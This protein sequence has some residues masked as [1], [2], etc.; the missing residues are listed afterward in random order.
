[1][2]YFFVSKALLRFMRARGFVILVFGA[3]LLAVQFA[4]EPVPTELP[5]GGPSVPVGPGDFCPSQQLDTNL[6]KCTALPVGAMHQAA[7]HIVGGMRVGGDAVALGFRFPAGVG[8][9]PKR[10]W[11]A[12]V[13]TVVATCSRLAALPLTA[14]GRASATGAYV[15]A[16][17]LCKAEYVGLTGRGDLG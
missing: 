17:L 16:T 14:F 12:L 7:P 8:A 1:M 11:Q 3:R 9:V 13:D 6:S 4:D 10:W 2:L 5:C 15:L